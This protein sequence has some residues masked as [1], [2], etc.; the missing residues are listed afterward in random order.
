MGAWIASKLDLQAI[1]LK[2]LLQPDVHKISIANPAHAP[3]GRAAVA[4]LQHENLS[5]KV[6]AKLVL[7]ENISQ[8]AQFVQSE[9]PTWALLRSLWP[10]RRRHKGRESISRSPS[11]TIRPSSKASCSKKLFS[12]IPRDK[13]FGFPQ[14]TGVTSLTRAVRIFFLAIVIFRRVVAL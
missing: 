8:A 13:I 7:G 4:A 11:V 9:T 6:E 2:V 3:Y 14:N 5:E 1:R 10:L 12:Q